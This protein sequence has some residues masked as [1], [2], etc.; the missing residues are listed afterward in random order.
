M[1]EIGRI[2]RLDRATGLVAPKGFDLSGV[3]AA[4]MDSRSGGGL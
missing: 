2:D 4:I 1:L 3:N